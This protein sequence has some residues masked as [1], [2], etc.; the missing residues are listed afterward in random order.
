[1][2]FCDE[3]KTE[4]IVLIGVRSIIIMRNF[5]LIPAEA[6]PIELR[7]VAIRSSVVHELSR[8]KKNSYPQMK[9]NC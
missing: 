8:A 5:F 4:L 7:C 3:K 9:R 2:R 6:T 1:M